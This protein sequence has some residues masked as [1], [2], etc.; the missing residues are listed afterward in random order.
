MYLGAG[1]NLGD[2][3]DEVANVAVQSRPQDVGQLR[4]ADARLL[5]D[6]RP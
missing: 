5:R 2:N 1:Q 6:L 4:D 3:P